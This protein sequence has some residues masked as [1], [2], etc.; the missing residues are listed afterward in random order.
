MS[1]YASTIADP[2]EV[3][4]NPMTIIIGKTT[5]GTVLAPTGKVVATDLENEADYN[6][7]STE[8]DNTYVFNTDDTYWITNKPIIINKDYPLKLITNYPYDY[9]LVLDRYNAFSI[10]DYGINYNY[11]TTITDSNN[12]GTI[13]IINGYLELMPGAKINNTGTITLKGSSYIDINYSST[14]TNKGTIDISNITDLFYWG[15]NGIFTLEEGSTFILPKSISTPNRND[16]NI[17]L[18]GSSDKP[19]NIVIPKGCEYITNIN[20]NNKEDLFNAIEDA[21]GFTFNGNTSNVSF[22]SI[23]HTLS[24]ITNTKYKHRM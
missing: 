22:I 4:T 9:K 8:E 3:I 18:S 19:V 17:T 16:F 20:N 10:D 23:K 6:Y 15:N 24:D 5:T 13:D 11:D 14:L 7:W 12:N 2:I 21:T 1:L